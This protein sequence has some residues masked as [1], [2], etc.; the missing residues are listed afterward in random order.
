MDNIKSVVLVRE[1]APER[2]FS[3]QDQPCP[4]PASGQV[5]IEVE[6]FGLNF[7]DVM[8]RKGL[9][10]DRPPLPTVLGYDVVGRISAAGSG[11]TRLKV[12]QRVTAMTRFGG[13]SQ[14]AV[15]QEPAAAV[16]PEDMDA[17]VALALT[18]QYCTAWYAAEECVRL[19][20]GE[21]VLVHAA[22]GGVGTALV[23][24]ALRRGAIVYGTAGSAEKLQALKVAGVHHTIA[25]RERDWD[26]QI[27]KLCGAWGLD[28]VWDSVGGTTFRKSLALLGAGGRMVAYGASS[29]SD[30]RNSFQRSLRGLAFGIY[31]P[32]R[33]LMPSQS[34][35]GVN[36]LRI[37]DERPTVL[38]R[39][40][41]SVVACT[42]AGELKPIVGGNFD[43]KDIAKAH[44]FLESRQSSG[45][46]VVRWM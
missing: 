31:H 19:Q 39:C 4:I 1:G 37:G 25:Y 29:L 24:L 9:Y 2:A 34:L 26:Q 13:Y 27:R 3:L 36:M 7:A 14:Y 22:A 40:L 16:I 45:K 33:F 42:A 44:A 20:A 21:Q 17:G 32:V 46:V 23:Q 12:G 11:V 41:R 8:A 6:A 15:T 28:V 10:R 18:T 43:V 35:I 38:E 5:L 30:A